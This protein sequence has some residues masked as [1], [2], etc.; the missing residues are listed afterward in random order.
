MHHL[1]G[2]SRNCRV[3]KNAWESIGQLLWKPEPSLWKFHERGTNS[4]C[5]ISETGGLSSM[6]PALS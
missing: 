5:V 6:V 1:R 3:K 2:G 4:C